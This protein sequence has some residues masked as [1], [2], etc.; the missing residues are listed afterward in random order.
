MTDI[1]LIRY[2]LTGDG[3]YEFNIGGALSYKADA[4]TFRSLTG[5]GE[6]TTGRLT[7]DADKAQ[8]LCHASAIV[9]LMD[10]WEIV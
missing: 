5:S 9:G 7:L 3:C 2:E 8:E 10:D 1:K 6:Y 4:A